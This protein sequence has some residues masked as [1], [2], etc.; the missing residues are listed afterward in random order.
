MKFPLS[1]KLITLALA[2]LLAT[3]AFAADSHK[4]S[5]QVFDP[6][7]V[8]GKN[9]PAGEYTVAWK[10]DGP[11]VTLNISHDGKVVAT[12]TAKIVPLEQKAEQDAAEVKSVS[13]GGRELT[14][15]RFSG[16]KYQLD[17]GAGSGQGDKSGDSMK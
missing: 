16:K 8:N 5:L 10:G 4:G 7:Q 11:D 6:V 1:S 17:I 14:A 2:T 9:L 13:A 3:T 12:A 15:I